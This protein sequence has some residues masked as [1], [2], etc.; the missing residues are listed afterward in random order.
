[1]ATPISPDTIIREC[2]AMY[3]HAY[4]ALNMSDRVNILREVRQI[5]QR[6]KSIVAQLESKQAV[7]KRHSKKNKD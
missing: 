7:T 6:M 1:M 5:R 2:K 4:N 3:K